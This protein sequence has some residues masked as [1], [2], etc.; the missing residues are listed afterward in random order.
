MLFYL[1]RIFDSIPINIRTAAASAV[2][3]LLS[4][5]LHIYTQD[6]IVSTVLVYMLI[7]AIALPIM[8][9]ISSVRVVVEFICMRHRIIYKIVIYVFDL[10]DII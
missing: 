10:C 6:A 2:L 4:S 7:V 5:Y 9:P 1:S 3:L 8:Y